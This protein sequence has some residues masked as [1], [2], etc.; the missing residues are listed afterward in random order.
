MQANQ[1]FKFKILIAESLAIASGKVAIDFYVGENDKADFFKSCFVLNICNLH[2]LFEDKFE[3]ACKYDE[4][5]ACLDD[6]N[7]VAAQWLMAF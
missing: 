6:Y 4:I 1:D 2:N 7:P 5:K 3:F